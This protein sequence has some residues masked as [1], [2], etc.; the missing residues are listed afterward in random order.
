MKKIVFF[1]IP[2]VMLLQSSLLFATPQKIEMIFLSPNKK[3]ALLQLLD[4]YKQ[5][6]MAA[7]TAQADDK[8]VPMGDGCFHPQL[9]YIEKKPEAP[10]LQVEQAPNPVQTFNSL[11]T[12]LV[13]CDKN[14]HFD[15]FCGKES[16]DKKK[17]AQTEVWFDISSSLREV[18]YSK[19][20]SSCARR[21]FMTQVQSACKGNVNFSVYNTSLKEMGDHSIVCESHG[22]NNEKRL[23]KWIKDSSAKTLL[24]VTD[25]DEL[26][27]EMRTLLD[28]NGAKMVGDGT[29]PFTS[30]QLIEY[31]K[32]FSKHC[33]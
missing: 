6:K 22:T 30:S 2:L 4:Q 21:T 3:A 32:E 27:P 17:F 11:E 33:N 13:N 26:S 9:G 24:I 20:G 19:D 5:L 7:Y 15:I 25:I 29:T 28:E 1:F 8:C 16:E 12:S 10:K 31:A 18:D 23:V 14:N